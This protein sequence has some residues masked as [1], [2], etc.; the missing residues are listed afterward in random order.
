MA[1][2]CEL[3]AQHPTGSRQLSPT[4]ST[5]SRFGWHPPCWWIPLS[6]HLAKGLAPLPRPQRHSRARHCHVQGFESVQ[7]PVSHLEQ[8]PQPP[9]SWCVWPAHHETGLLSAGVAPG[10]SCQTQGNTGFLFSQVSVLLLANLPW[11]SP[12]CTSHPGVSPSPKLQ[13]TPF[14][15]GLPSAPPSPPELAQG[16]GCSAFAA[17][18]CGEV[19]GVT[20][21]P[22][23]HRHPGDAAVEV[24]I[25]AI[26]GLFSGR[27]LAMNKRDGSTLR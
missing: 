25:V 17:G 16:K 21:I 3:P 5:A 26:K 22:T 6:V 9:V 10:G 27:Y 15:C 12:F 4:T 1:S 13:V 2:L 18:L 14:Q 8:V 11:C 24:G 20:G 19:E 7:T 23:P